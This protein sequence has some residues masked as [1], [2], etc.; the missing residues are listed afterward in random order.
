MGYTSFFYSV[1]PFSGGAPVGKGQKSPLETGN[2]SRPDPHGSASILRR[3]PSK[4]PALWR[5]NKLAERSAGKHYP[6]R[7][8]PKREDK[9][10]LGGSPEI[11]VFLPD[12][13]REA[14][15]AISQGLVKGM[16]LKQ[17]GR[18]GG[19][20]AASRRLGDNPLG[21]WGQKVI[22]WFLA[23]SGLGYQ[24][25]M[26]CRDSWPVAREPEGLPGDLRLCASLR[27]WQF[28]ST[29]PKSHREW[30]KW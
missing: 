14:G 9:F 29:L 8:W 26:I 3:I 23:W 6:P 16:W 25:V 13:G 4:F 15:F 17:N 27:I 20:I 30:G 11:A 10:G 24:V 5:H 12:G 19:G 7:G 22:R 2:N 18:K 28:S 1:E 21:L